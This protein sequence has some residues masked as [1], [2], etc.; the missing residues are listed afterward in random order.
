MPEGCIRVPRSNRT[1]HITPR[2][3]FLIDIDHIGASK[4]L[5]LIHHH[6]NDVFIQDS[7]TL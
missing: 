4:S 1:D 6:T 2:H 7:I 3:M 5:S